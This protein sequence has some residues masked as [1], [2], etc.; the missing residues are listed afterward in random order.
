[1]NEEFSF[2][3]ECLVDEGYDL[4]DYTWDEMYEFYENLIY[5]ETLKDKEER[6]AE[7]ARR[8][9]RVK[10][11]QSQGRVM[12]STKR[13]S[14]RAAERR[15]EKS[16]EARERELAKLASGV[17]ASMGHTGK[18]SEKPMGSEGPAPKEAAPEATRRLNP[19]LRK[20]TLGTAADRILRDIQKEDYEL[21]LDYLLDEGYV[22]DYESAEQLVEHMSQDWLEN[23]FESEK[24]IQKAIKKPGSLR[25]SLKVKTG[26][27][28]SAKTLKAASR[29]GGKMGKRARLAMTLRKFH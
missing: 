2:W 17:L 23:I 29:K 6:E 5:E 8:R 7:I 14:A 27:N 12:T 22:N 15:Q 28:I 1:M 4:S 26:K 16:Q 11:L 19:K 20:D 18:V 3:V 21:L 9:A 25:A 24:W 10:Q 13:T